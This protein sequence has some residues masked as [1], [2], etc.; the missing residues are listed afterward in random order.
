MD[1]QCPSWRRILGAKV[2]IKYEQQR[3]EK[4]ESKKEWKVA[5]WQFLELHGSGLG[6]GGDLGLRLGL[7]LGL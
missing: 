3:K 6:F 2:K 4:S 5:C 1:S 7:R